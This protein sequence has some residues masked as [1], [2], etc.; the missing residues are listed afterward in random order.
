M[1]AEFEPAFPKEGELGATFTESRISTIWPGLFTMTCP[2]CDAYYMAAKTAPRCDE[3][4]MRR[5]EA[6]GRARPSTEADAVRARVDARK[7]E[8]LERSLAAITARYIQVAAY[9]YGAFYNPLKEPVVIEARTLLGE[10][11][12]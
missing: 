3:C 11:S 6:V 5:L 4:E 1:H 8:Q 12:E 9:A 10:V 2:H 7:I